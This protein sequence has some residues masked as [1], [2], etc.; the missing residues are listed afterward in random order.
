MHVATDSEGEDNDDGEGDGDGEVDPDS[1]Y[2][3]GD[4]KSLYSH[5]MW[6]SAFDDTD[7]SSVKSVLNISRYCEQYT[8]H[9][10]F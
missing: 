9:T 6:L 8:S 5:H 3:D 2:A 4:G 1:M 10:N 7:A